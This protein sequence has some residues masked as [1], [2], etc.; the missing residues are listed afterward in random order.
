M[1]DA[2]QFDTVPR[3]DISPTADEVVVVRDTAGHALYPPSDL[4][5]AI[6]Y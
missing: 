4:I 1:A 2:F 6:N 5:A 3:R